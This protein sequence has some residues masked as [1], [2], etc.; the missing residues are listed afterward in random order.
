MNE[1]I[2]VSLNFLIPIS[3]GTRLHS[4]SIDGVAVVREIAE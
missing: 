4:G 1:K 3:P 2:N